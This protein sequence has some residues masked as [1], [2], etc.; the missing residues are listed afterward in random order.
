MEYW[1]DLVQCM[2]KMRRGEPRVKRMPIAWR[3][4]LYEGCV[5]ISM[6]RPCGLG[7]HMLG[8]CHTAYLGTNLI[9]NHASNEITSCPAP[10]PR[11]MVK[12]NS[13]KPYCNMPSIPDKADNTCQGVDWHSSHYLVWLFPSVLEEADD[14]CQGVCCRS[15]NCTAR[16]G[17]NL[18]V[19]PYEYEWVTIDLV[20]K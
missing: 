5:A 8:S 14:N 20:T 16:G 13:P 19:R 9:R 17:K 18:S 11:R 2:F 4:L 15:V 10:R 3:S 7:C 1:I 6:L 12:D